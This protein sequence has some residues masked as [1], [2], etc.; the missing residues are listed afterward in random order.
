[1][2]E[3]K[4]ATLLMEWLRRRAGD[5]AAGWLE[6]ALVEV[7]AGD[8][9]RLAIAFSTA[10]RKVGKADLELSA[11]DLRRAGEARPGW[12]PSRWSADQAARTLLALS[13]PADDPDAYG[14]LLDRLFRAGDVG[15]QVALYQ[16]LPLL[17]HPE[18][19]TLRAAEGVRSNIKAVF[20]AVALRNPF[21]SERFDEPA[22]NQ[23]VLKCLFV[24]SPL[25]PVVGLDRRANANLARMLTDYARE[26]RAA[27]R[28]I[29]PELWRCVGPFADDETVGWLASLLESGGPHDRQ[30]AALALAANSS[31]GAK[32]ALQRFPDAARR[33]A[34]GEW[35]WSALA[36]A[37]PGGP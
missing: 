4:P 20:E 35:T 1:M 8:A 25:D 33:V 16:A 17:P 19:H 15:E 34:A 5:E 26:R 18:R 3:S 6:S 9:R 36:P 32:S 12:D 23:M 2:A 10:S 28:S 13:P 21:P 11:D 14:A 29:H 27:G 30:A 7:R 24:E 37:S 22:W 31:P